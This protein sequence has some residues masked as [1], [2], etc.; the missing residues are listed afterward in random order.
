MD[1]S[2]L[3][4]ASDYCVIKSSHSY[5]EFLNWKQQQKPESS[6]PRAKSFED[7]NNPANH[8]LIQIIFFVSKTTKN[9]C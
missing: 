8:L 2:G 5:A 4:A 6:E 1:W 9:K 3:F 7:N